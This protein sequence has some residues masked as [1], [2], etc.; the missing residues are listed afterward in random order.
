MG[1]CGGVTDIDGWGGG[2]G[3]CGGG[4]DIDLYIMSVG[5]GCEGAIQ[6]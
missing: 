5:G 6:S 3:Q 4:T 2:M 1:Q